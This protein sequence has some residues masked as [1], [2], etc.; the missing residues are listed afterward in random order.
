MPQISNINKQIE[1]TMLKRLFPLLFLAIALTACEKYPGTSDLSGKLMVYTHY[2]NHCDFSSFRTYHIADSLL[3][4]DNQK[5]KPEYLSRDDFRAEVIIATIEDMMNAKGYIKVKD[6]SQA[7]MGV[8]ASYIS[9]TNTYVGYDY[10]WWY[11]YYWPM[12]YWDPFYNGWYPYYPYP[13]SYSYTVGTLCI[14]IANLKDAKT[15]SEKKIPFVW[16]AL[17]AGVESTGQINVAKA[18]S[19][20]YQAFEQSPYIGR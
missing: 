12:D 18:S 10:Y 17:M 13:V 3:I 6:D 15:S 9:N 7:D 4:L 5:L 11:D 14:E 8:I 20:I 19:S 2:D 16:T 1:T